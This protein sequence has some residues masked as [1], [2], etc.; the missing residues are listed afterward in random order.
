MPPAALPHFKGG[1]SDHSLPLQTGAPW[2]RFLPDAPLQRLRSSVASCPLL[3]PA[4][5]LALC[6]SANEN[7]G[8][9]PLGPAPTPVLAIP[10][11]P[12]GFE[13]PESFL[14][15]Q[16]PSKDLKVSPQ[17]PAPDVRFHNRIALMSCGPTG[18]A[19]CS[20]CG[21]TPVEGCPMVVSAE[22]TTGP[23]GICVC[24]AYVKKAL[25]GWCTTKGLQTP[26]FPEIEEPC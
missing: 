25:E 13:H 26:K 8:P 6:S 5:T 18:S 1:H 24:R 3:A 12:S 7:N 21:V 14:R 11:A 20:V 17:N 10:A 16:L 19:H 4:V 22:P 2:A 9:G 15:L 23:Q